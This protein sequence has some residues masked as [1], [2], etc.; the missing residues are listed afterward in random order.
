[1]KTDSVEVTK[2]AN[3]WLVKTFS[4][5]HSEEA[6]TQIFVF[7]DYSHVLTFIT[8]AFEED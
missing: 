1:M 6:A 4:F 5:I 2:V 3:G 8:G 7:S